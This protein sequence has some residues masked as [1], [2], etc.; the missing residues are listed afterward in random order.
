MSLKCLECESASFQSWL[1][2]FAKV[3]LKLQYALTKVFWP[4]SLDSWVSCIWLPAG[5]V[6]APTLAPSCPTSTRPARTRPAQPRSRK[7]SCK[8]RLLYRVPKFLHPYCDEI[9]IFG[10]S[11]FS[12]SLLHMYVDTTCLVVFSDRRCACPWATLFLH[13]RELFC[14][15]LWQCW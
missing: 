7:T 10:E 12:L 13:T 3:C 14:F 2:I 8:I 9:S 1:E 11:A 5:G 4:W 6:T 15:K